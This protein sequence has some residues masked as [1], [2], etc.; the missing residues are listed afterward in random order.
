MIVSLNEVL[1]KAKMHHYAVGAFNVYNLESAQAVIAAAEDLKSPVIMQTSNKALEYGGH[2]NLAMMLVGMAQ[3]A[4]TPVVVHLDHGKDLNIAKRCLELG[5]S[6]VMVDFSKLTFSE[7]IERTNEVVKLANKHQASVEAE[8]GRILGNEDGVAGSS[9]LTNPDEA[10]IFVREVAISALAVGIGNAH[11]AQP[12]KNLN[13]DLLKTINQ[14]VHIPLVLHGA[15]SIEAG[16]IA[17][18]ISFGVCKI[19][20]DTSLRQAFSASVRTFL[21]ANP[22]VYDPRDIIGV[23]R[24]AIKKAVVEHIKMFGSEGGA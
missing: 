18:A 12:E 7:N 8:L 16:K 22:A 4:S 17:K 15:S 10:E 19:N 3:R 24:N 23:G 9:D 21:H 2:E 13:F 6:S 5:F 14:K 20:I 1:P 11:G